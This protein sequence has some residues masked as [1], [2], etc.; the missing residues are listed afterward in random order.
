MIE[1]FERVLEE[2]IKM[3]TSS[4]ADFSDIGH[5]GMIGDMYEGLTGDVL[6]AGLL[7]GTNT[8]VR[9]GKIKA[10]TANG[11][12]YSNQVDCMVVIGEGERIP[13]T[14][15]YIY[16]INDVIAVVEVKKTLTR[17]EL[18]DAMSKLRSVHD[19]RMKSKVVSDDHVA[20]ALRVQRDAF[21]A[22]FRRP[23]PGDEPG[24]LSS[25]ETDPERMMYSAIRMSAAMPIMVIW[26]YSGHQTE[27]GFRNCLRE[28][29]KKSDVDMIFS[30]PDCILSG[31]YLY[32]KSTGMPFAHEAPS[33]GDFLYAYTQRGLKS[34][35]ILNLLWYRMCK[36]FNRD[37]MI[38]ADGRAYSVNPLLSYTSESRRKT[39][40]RYYDI[41]DQD[42]RTRKIETSSPAVLSLEEWAAFTLLFERNAIDL[43]DQ[44]EFV[45]VLQE[46][47]N[48]LVKLCDASRFKSPMRMSWS[49]FSQLIEKIT[50]SR[51][52][53]VDQGKLHLVTSRCV[54]MAAT[55]EVVAF[56]NRD[57]AFN[58]L[59][60]DEFLEYL[61]SGMVSHNDNT[62]LTLFRASK[63]GAGAGA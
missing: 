47:C 50:S 57:G 42:L 51:L 12:L 13:H 40:I 10:D 27:S 37:F 22:V 48:Q 29:L 23:Y 16:D 5:Q 45:R 56:D 60:P 21:R 58:E 32:V 7:T 18:E 36:R 54:V 41:S 46:S 8:R 49:T 26:G 25:F 39:R 59:F 6:R 35:T 30:G 38:L 3:G 63:G 2:I 15:H 28:V 52:I 17:R 34:R 31:D 9:R 44:A 4:N 20:M 1:T 61:R 53:A 24:V 11:R 19:I 14:D 62:V 33:R 55:N 43:E